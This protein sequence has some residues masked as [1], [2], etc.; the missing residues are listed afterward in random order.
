MDLTVKTIETGPFAGLP[1]YAVS[2]DE[3]FDEDVVMAAIIGYTPPIAHFRLLVDADEDVDASGLVGRLKAIGLFV[4]VECVMDVPP[5][6]TKNAS[7]I[8]LHLGDKATP[9]VAN[10]F[11]L[12]TDDPPAAFRPP[13]AQPSGWLLSWAPS[14]IIKPSDFDRIPNGCRL[15]GFHSFVI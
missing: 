5:W 15:V 10:E 3:D 12:H 13:I 11:V 1:T 9:F 8:V 6:V 7:Y 14:R 4:T 2:L